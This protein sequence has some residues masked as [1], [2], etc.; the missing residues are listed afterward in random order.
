M[1]FSRIAKIRG[2][3][4]AKFRLTELPM[5][6]L[7]MIFDLI[8]KYELMGFWQP[9]IYRNKSLALAMS[10]LLLK[11]VYFYNIPLSELHSYFAIDES[12]LLVRHYLDSRMLIPRSSQ[13]L[14]RIFRFALR[15]FQ[16]V[17]N[18]ITI[19]FSI[20]SGASYLSLRNLVDALYGLYGCLYNRIRIYIHFNSSMK[21][22]PKMPHLHSLHVANYGDF[23]NISELLLTDFVLDGNLDGE[24]RCYPKGLRH[25]LINP[26]KMSIGQLSISLKNL[27]ETVTAILLGENVKI[28]DSGRVIPSIASVISRIENPELLSFIYEFLRFN[29]RSIKYLQLKR[30]T[31]KKEDLKHFEVLKV[32]FLWKSSDIPYDSLHFFKNLKKL[33]LLECDLNKIEKLTIPSKLKDIRIAPCDTE[34]LRTLLP[35]YLRNKISEERWI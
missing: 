9:E 2:R 30:M 6:L 28:L 18:N 11:D 13:M 3:N 14:F 29:T 32:L 12:W 16:I 35:D 15:N 8:P 24:I 1:L 20:S 5:E 34:Y 22:I 23:D 4:K 31:I 27:P 33:W 19:L 7:L 10:Y 25:L 21:R 17:P 26:N